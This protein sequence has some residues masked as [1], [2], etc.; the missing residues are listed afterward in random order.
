MITFGEARRILSRISYKDWTL[1]SEERDNL[2]LAIQW[3]FQAPDYTVPGRP[4]K[5]WCSAERVIDL[6]SAT[7]DSLA[8]AAFILAKQ[9]EEHETLEAFM[10]DGVAVFDPHKPII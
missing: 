3:Y 9:A 8:K 10:I 6:H 4:E 5:S 7:P 1:D 2:D